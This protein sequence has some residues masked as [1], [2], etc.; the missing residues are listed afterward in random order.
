M[1]RSAVFAARGF[2][3]GDGRW[4]YWLWEVRCLGVGGEWEMLWAQEVVYSLRAC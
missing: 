3:G 1:G 2:G 4:M